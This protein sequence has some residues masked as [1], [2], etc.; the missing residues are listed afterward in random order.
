MEKLRQQLDGL[1]N[2]LENSDEIRAN[3]ELLVSIYP[4]N[5]FEFVISHLLA[6]KKLT[7]DE[8]NKLRQEYIKRNLYLYV[9][10]ISAPRGFG[11]TWA[12]K[13]L[14]KLAPNLKKPNKKLDANYSGQYDFILS[15]NIKI[16]VKASREVEF[17]SDEP[18]YIKALS[19]DSDKRFDMNFQQI[20]PACCDVFVWLAV[21]R[22][23]IKFW[24]LSSFEIEN[25]PHYSAGQHRGNIGE[26]QLHLNERNIKEFDEYLSPLNKIEENIRKAFEREKKIRKIKK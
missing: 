20:K 15:P 2:R 1:L 6:N 8:Y 7:L 13:E 16:E 3:L 23:E 12:Q 4:F 9:F 25:N 17:Q 24:V 19:S 22:D 14:Q 5:E 10:E 26:G 21:W 18:L 11:E